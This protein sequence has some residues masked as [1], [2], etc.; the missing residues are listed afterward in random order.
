MS[1]AGRLAAFALVLALALLAG[2]GIGA[3]VGPLR[4]DSGTYPVG[5]TIGPV[6][7]QV[8]TTEVAR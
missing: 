7:V 5:T 2:L 8:D 4:A 6:V 1:D 3:A